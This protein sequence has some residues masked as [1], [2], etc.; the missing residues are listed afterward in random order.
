LQVE[1]GLRIP[2]L[3]TRIADA[4]REAARLACLERVE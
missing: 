1:A 4:P 2:I 3:D